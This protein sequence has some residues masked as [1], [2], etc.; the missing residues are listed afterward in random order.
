MW[1][2]IQTIS[3]LW[4]VRQ[5]KIADSDSFSTWPHPHPILRASLSPL[6]CS[7]QLSTSWRKAAITPLA[8]RHQSKKRPETTGDSDATPSLLRPRGTVVPT[9]NHIPYIIYI[10]VYTIICIWD[11][12]SIL[13]SSHIHARSEHSP[14]P[15]VSLISPDITAWTNHMNT[16]RLSLNPPGTAWHGPRLLV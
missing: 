4:W 5:T 14:S 8:G 13:L 7:L 2:P 16:W 12:N 9:S 3:V 6:T 1:H 11:N 10:Y 15:F